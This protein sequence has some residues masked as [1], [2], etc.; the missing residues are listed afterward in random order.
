[1]IA[2]LIGII[3]QLV[4]IIILLILLFLGHRS[5]DKNNSKIR[6]KLNEIVLRGR[7]YPAIQ[8]CVQNRYLIL[9]AVFTY[10]AFIVNSVDFRGLDLTIKF[11]VNLIVS[12]I[13]VGAVWHN[14]LNYVYNNIE[15]RK[16][17]GRKKSP[18]FFGTLWNS[19]MEWMF[20]LAM[21]LLILGAYVLTYWIF[22]SPSKF[23]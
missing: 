9:V 16:L 4:F 6:A 20:S 2:Y 5:G 13:F 23:M 12:I 19:R 22:K 21:F 1:M 14:L 8:S 11:I 17:E 10:Y 15:E 7:I 18:E 3:L